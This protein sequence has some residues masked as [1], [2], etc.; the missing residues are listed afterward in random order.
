MATLIK[1]IADLKKYVSVNR[2]LV[3]ESVKPYIHQAERKYIKIIIGDLLYDDYTTTIPTGNELK[4]FNLFQE[5]SANLAWFL[6][7]PLANVQITDTGISVTEGTNFKAAAWW[8]IRD[9]RRSFLDAGF[10]AIDEALKIMEANEAD[11]SPWE[12]TEGY[13]IFKELFVKRTDT[14]QRWFN[15][16][17]SRKTFLALRPYVLET[18][19]Q[20]FTS[21]LNEATITDINS[22]AEVVHKQVLD[23]LQAAQVNYAVVKAINSGAFDLSVAGLQPKLTELPNNKTNTYDENQIHRVKQERQNAAEEYFKKAITLIEANPT[24]F[25][26]YQTKATPVFVAPKNTKSTVAL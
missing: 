20:Y 7:L 25:P 1:N 4:A 23:L 8:Q 15:I 24:D 2:N 22:A 19:H 6:Y 14:F 5:A 10:E 9:L 11:F 13:T 3:W 21:L 12:T 17:N 16:N 18:H 26:D